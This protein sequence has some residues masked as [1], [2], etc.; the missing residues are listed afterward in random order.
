MVDWYVKE[1]DRQQPV[2]L[3]ESSLRTNASGRESKD[4]M[5]LVLTAGSTVKDGVQAMKSTAFATC[6]WQLY[7]SAQTVHLRARVCSAHTTKDYSTLE[8][9]HLFDLPVPLGLSINQDVTAWCALLENVDAVLLLLDSILDDVRSVCGRVEGTTPTDL[10]MRNLTEHQQPRA[11]A[12][13][14]TKMQPKNL[15]RNFAAGHPDQAS[16]APEV[17]APPAAVVP[18]KGSGGGDD[19]DPKAT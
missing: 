11:R 16:A 18:K 10:K 14:R 15:D 13:N 19:D 17:T 5:K 4:F 3:G 12:K 6:T 2:S 7:Q 8:N 1:P 9:H